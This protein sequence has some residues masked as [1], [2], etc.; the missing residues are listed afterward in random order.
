[1][2]AFT[3]LAHRR[4]GPDPSNIISGARRASRSRSCSSRTGAVR[5]SWGRVRNGRRRAATFRFGSAARCGRRNSMRRWSGRFVPPQV[6]L[7]RRLALVGLNSVDFLATANTFQLLEINPRPGATLDI[8]THPRLFSAH[9]ESCRG[10]LPSE[11]LVFTTSSA[12][13]IAYAPCDLAFMPELDW[14]AWCVD[15]QKP[16]TRLRKGDPVC[17]VFGRSRASARR[18]GPWL[19]SVSRR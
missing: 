14:P 12:T 7:P 2:A 11:P 19:A 1:M 17:T 15:R 8:F 16:G 10:L 3:W 4:G 5:R 18:R 9:L 13:A 6:S